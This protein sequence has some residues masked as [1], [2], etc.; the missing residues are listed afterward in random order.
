MKLLFFIGSLKAGG[1]ERAV[2]RLMNHLVGEGYTVHL[3]IRKNIIQFDLDDRITIHLLKDYMGRNKAVTVLLLRKRLKEVIRTVQPDAVCSFA[4][5][6]S[7]LLA[8]TFT[9][10][11]IVRFD[12]YPRDLKTWKQTLFYTF[13]NLPHVKR[14]IC[15]THEA[16]KDLKGFLPAS[17]IEV[18]QIPS[19]SQENVGLVPATFT[20]LQLKRH[21]LISIGRLSGG[22]A[23][24]Y[25]LQAYVH[26]KVY[27]NLDFV[28]VGD[29]PMRQ[30][31]QEYVVEENIERYVHFLGHVRNPYPILKGAQYLIHTS[32]REGFGNVLLEALSFDVPIISTNCKSG[33]SDIIDEGIN[34]FLVPMRDVPA[35][36]EK[37]QLLATD[38]DLRN[39]LSVNAAQSIARFSEDRIYDKWQQ[40]F[41]SL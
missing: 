14:V 17:K 6:T 33:P 2:S 29:G 41:N 7:V 30:S 25:A 32:L 21:Y 18:I 8:S 31:L 5:L 15:L 27:E 19:V 36:A 10:N 37:M 12:T 23:Y 4:A 11:T 20:D 28:V 16:K 22:K 13:F 34:G 1:A 26:G 39:R 3:V 35:I 40:L 24:R 9:A 38:V